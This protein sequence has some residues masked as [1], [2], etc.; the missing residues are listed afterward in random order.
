ME[1]EFKTLVLKI[2]KEK[3]CSECDAIVIAYEEYV[4]N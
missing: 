2:M 4:K 3:G 1:K